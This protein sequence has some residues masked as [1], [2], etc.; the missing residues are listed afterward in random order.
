MQGVAIE[1]AKQKQ[2]IT[3]LVFVLFN[4]VG[5]FSGLFVFLRMPA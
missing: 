3:G 1:V 5:H 2:V 4:I